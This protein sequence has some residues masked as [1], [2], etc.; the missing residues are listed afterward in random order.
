MPRY[1]SAARHERTRGP[2]GWR[3]DDMMRA[4]LSPHATSSAPGRD[5]VHHRPGMV[6]RRVTEVPPG[7]EF[8]WNGSWNEG[9]APTSAFRAFWSLRCCVSAGR[10]RG[11]VSRL[12]VNG[13]SA[14]RSRS[15]APTEV[16]PPGATVRPGPPGASAV[17][18]A[19]NRGLIHSKIAFAAGGSNR[20][21]GRSR[22][23]PESPG[24]TAD[25]DAPSS[26]GVSPG[27]ASCA[28]RS[29]WLR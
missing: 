22:Y 13:R 3:S 14:V 21:S 9:T 2:G 19:A 8:A 29:S 26:S 12:L 7:S 15:P 1:P 5:V 28:T 4:A 6:I 17:R 11:A 10:A 18:S 24:P 16:R 20:R 25:K 23:A 27:L